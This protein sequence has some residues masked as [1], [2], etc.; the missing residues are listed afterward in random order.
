M[1][2]ASGS[3]GTEAG[4]HLVRAGVALIA[5]VWNEESSIRAFLAGLESQTVHPQEI[6]VVDGGSAD[7]TVDILHAWAPWCG[8]AVNVI[9]QPGAGIS[10]GRNGAI[11]AASM[12]VIAVT[13][14]G[15]EL[16]RDWFE[17][18]TE[19]L[20]REDPPDV[21]SGFFEPVGTTLIERAIAV[22]ITPTA[23]E[24]RPENFMPSSRSVLFSRTAW[25]RAGGYPEWLDY[26]EDLV[27]DLALKGTGAR[28]EF[29]PRAI[30]GWIGRP[31]LS[32]FAKQYY[33]YARGDGKSDLFPRRHAARYIAYAYALVAALFLTRLPVLLLVGC[34]GFVVYMARPVKRV[35]ARRA[36]F[37]GFELACAVILSPVIVVVGDV[38][39]MVG[40][41][42]GRIWRRRHASEIPA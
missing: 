36:K 39:K 23:S 27:F 38:A 11:T 35:L 26:C 33:R 21:V 24:I 13:D 42:V 31:S 3:P 15:T 28:F 22:T 37:R 5:T 32:A 12:P 18:L 40:Y 17:R 7:R 1:D 4:T 6:V 8:C 2:N 14:A 16:R 41:P 20:S 34:G 29:Q 30:A 9:V 10:A 19:P 25:A